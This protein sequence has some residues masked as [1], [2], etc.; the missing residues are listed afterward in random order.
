MTH[1]KKNYLLRDTWNCQN[2]SESVQIEVNIE[3]QVETHILHEFLE[4]PH[5]LNRE[6]E[7]SELGSGDVIEE[8][9]DVGIRDNSVE[10]NVQLALQVHQVEE[11]AQSTGKTLSQNLIAAWRRWD[12]QR[13][14]IQAMNLSLC[15]RGKAHNR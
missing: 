8:G 3:V 11:S 7:C 6:D 2:V 14:G 12:Q 5:V 15:H 4:L 13:T 1:S 9:R 10:E